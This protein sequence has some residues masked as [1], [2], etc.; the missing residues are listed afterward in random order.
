METQTEEKTE[1]EVEEKKTKKKAPPVDRKTELLAKKAELERKSKYLSKEESTE[2]KAILD[3]E[4]LVRR[5]GA[6]VHNLC[7]DAE[8]YGRKTGAAITR[9]ITDRVAK[10]GASERDE[11][12]ISVMAS[13]N[14][15][16]ELRKEYERKQKQL[17][18]DLKREIEEAHIRLGEVTTGIH[19][20]YRAQ[21]DEA[22]QDMKSQHMGLA[23]MISDFHDEIKELTLEEL[24]TLAK[25]GVLPRGKGDFLVAPGI[26][27]PG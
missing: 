16:K 1:V 20:K 11:T 23:I 22:E 27:K 21:Y 3:A 4:E 6:L 7:Q 18:V 9:Q 25:D 8:T 10:F 15:V 24:E 17:Q 12:S 19:E 14:K 26:N 2:L 13:N 5:R